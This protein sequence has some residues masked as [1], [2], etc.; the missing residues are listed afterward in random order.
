M[1]KV[2][3]VKSL[4]KSNDWKSALREA[5]DFRINVTK[6]QRS[7]MARAYECIVHPQF[8]LSIG[9]NLE[10]CIEIGK[11]VLLSVTGDIYA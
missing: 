9:K 4:I 2:D 5:K 8:Y 10:E 7:D 11:K 6:Q 1:S 3:L